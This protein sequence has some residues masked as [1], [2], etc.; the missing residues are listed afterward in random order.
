MNK[1]IKIFAIIILVQIILVLAG[2][3]YQ[4]ASG[5]K[6]SNHLH[7]LSEWYDDYKDKK[8]NE[9]YEKA[10]EKW[11]NSLTPVQKANYQNEMAEIDEK[12][13]KLIVE[14]TQEFKDC[15]DEERSILLK[16][17]NRYAFALAE[18]NC[19]ERLGFGGISSMAE[20]EEKQRELMGF[21]FR[22]QRDEWESEVRLKYKEP[23]R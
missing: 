23:E 12:F 7:D 1:A 3:M 19:H 20:N 2:W 9:K 15:V 18:S 6:I 14:K 16:S 4:K 17:R 21:E 11:W 22:L 5:N 13:K 8:A 10:H